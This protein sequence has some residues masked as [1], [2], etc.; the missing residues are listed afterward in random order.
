MENLLYLIDVRTTKPGAK[1]ATPKDI[2]RWQIKG[3]YAFLPS[4]D[5]G[6]VEATANHGRDQHI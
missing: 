5:A 1:N 2:I 4:C 3:E 6:Y